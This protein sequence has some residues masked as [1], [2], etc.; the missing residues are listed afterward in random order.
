M[1]NPAPIKLL[2]TGMESVRL[3]AMAA[4]VRNIDATTKNTCVISVHLRGV[5]SRYRVTGMPAYYNVSSLSGDARLP[6]GGVMDESEFVAFIASNFESASVTLSLSE[7]FGNK[8][9][10]LMRQDLTQELTVERH[11]RRVLEPTPSVPQTHQPTTPLNTGH[12]PR[13]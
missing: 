8:I 11:Q 6:S 2:P 4:C 13:R 1:N 9:A 5:Q 7:S 10:S 3:Q 12:R